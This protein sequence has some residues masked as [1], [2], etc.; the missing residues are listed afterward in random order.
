MSVAS[1]DV[2]GVVPGVAGVW[3]EAARPAAASATTANPAIAIRFTFIF[4]RITS[5]LRLPTSVR[6]GR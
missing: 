5:S 1:D 3:A 2:T 4:I 6:G